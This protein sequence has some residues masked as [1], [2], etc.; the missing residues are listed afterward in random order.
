M[1]ASPLPSKFLPA[2]GSRVP[3][4]NLSILLLYSTG[5][6]AP[7]PWSRHSIPG[8]VEDAVW[9][10][11]KKTNALP[12]AGVFHT[13]E[14]PPRALPNCAE[15]SLRARCFTVI[16]GWFR[17]QNA[18][19]RHDPQL[20]SVWRFHVPRIWMSSI[21]PCVIAVKRKS[22]NLD[23]FFFTCL[24]LVVRFPARPSHFLLHS[25][26]FFFLNSFRATRYA[27]ILVSPRRSL[28]RFRSNPF[29][30]K[31]SRAGVSS[32]AFCQKNSSPRHP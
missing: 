16:P 19:P 27:I 23:N 15:S 14:Q 10:N 26:T 24:Y 25:T 32:A 30:R 13:A 1:L 7:L 17:G 20:W 9:E 8:F 12:G 22:Q 31:I 11:R 6:R 18:G 5:R 29:S 21:V 3:A 28:F 2:A 4:G